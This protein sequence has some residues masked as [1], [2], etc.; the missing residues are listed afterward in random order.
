MKTR[1]K[2]AIAAIVLILFC[3]FTSNT[4]KAQIRAT[5]YE[6]CNYIGKTTKLEPGSY[7]LDS[8]LIGIRRL[9]SIQLPSG[10][11]LIAY[12]S[13]Y[14]SNNEVIS[15]AGNNACIDQESDYNVTHFDII[16][17]STETSK[18]RNQNNTIEPVKIFDACFYGGNVF[19]LSTGYYNTDALASSKI[20]SISS[21]ELSPGYILVVFSKPDF[22]GTAAIIS[23][24]NA[25]MQWEWKTDIASIIVSPINNIEQL[26]IDE[27]NVRSRSQATNQY[28]KVLYEDAYAQNSQFGLPKVVYNNRPNVAST[29]TVIVDDLSSGRPI[30]NGS[31]NGYSSST[32][33]F[34]SAP[35]YVNRSPLVTR[36][37][38]SGITYVA[39]ES[40][41]DMFEMAKSANAV[42]L[43]ENCNAAGKSITLFPNQY[44]ATTLE[45]IGLKVNEISSILIPDNWVVTIFE[46]DNFQ[47]AQTS[48]HKSEQCLSKKWNNKIGSIKIEKIK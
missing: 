17:V 39:A 44:S 24:S 2:S 45:N 3:V 30:I 1:E 13:K 31:M 40:I 8:N 21:V 10:L 47:G 5:L 14:Q 6:Q 26:N 27:Y 46:L 36:N 38:N 18:A 16:E 34:R 33:E 28:R 42:T 22:Q 41:P 20:T 9:G 37:N 25:C 15:Y 35:D 29:P 12:S 32:Y 48:F 43:F 7:D 19:G 11:R 4:S 23:Q